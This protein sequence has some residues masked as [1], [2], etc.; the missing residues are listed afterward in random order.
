[1]KALSTT[2]LI[3]VTAVVILVA[4]LVVL[5]IFGGGVGTVGTLTSFRSQCITQCQLTCKMG[6]LP[7]TWYA[8]VNVQGIGQTSCSAQ[9]TNLQNDCGCT[10][11]GG[12]I[13]TTGAVTCGTAPNCASCITCWKTDPGGFTRTSYCVQPGTSCS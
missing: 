13:P 6:S 9:V 10:G 12:N 7:P 1:M 11:T 2:I 4:A 8:M 3:V 5:T